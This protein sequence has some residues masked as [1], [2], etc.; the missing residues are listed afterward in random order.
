LTE[1]KKRR[2][3]LQSARFNDGEDT[4]DKSAAAR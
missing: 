2:S 1:K 4:G 3:L